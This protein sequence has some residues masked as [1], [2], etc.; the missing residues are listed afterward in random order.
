MPHTMTAYGLIFE[1]QAPDVLALPYS[2]APP[3]AGPADV[4]LQLGAVPHELDD[5]EMSRT[6]WQAAPG[7]FLF[8]D[9]ALGRVLVTDGARI[10]AEPAP[11][12]SPQD[13]TVH[14]QGSVTAALLFQRGLV[15]FHASAIVHDGAAVLFSGT[16]GA[17]KSTLLAE[18]LRRGAVAL[19]DDISTIKLDAT[20]IP[21]VLPAFPKTRL[22]D[23]TIEAFDHLDS[24]QAI[25]RVQKGL[26]KFILPMGSFANEPYPLK[27]VFILGDPDASLI[28]AKGLALVQHL[29]TCTYRRR[30]VKPLGMHAAQFKVLTRIADDVPVVPLPRSNSGF[31]VEALADRVEAFLAKPVSV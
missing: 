11:G 30:L 19:A 9:D 17:G 1:N 10:V 16:S 24:A 14:L 28:G 6:Q 29:A 25:G 5:A 27:A 18:F 31:D 22:W 20:G 3:T 4:V 13:L 21:Q 2:E 8:R 7:R 15:P 23:D 26:E 12:A